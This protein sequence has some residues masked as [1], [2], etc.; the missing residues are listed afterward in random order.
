VQE[1]Q[2]R[3]A[4]PGRTIR[5]LAGPKTLL[6]SEGPWRTLEVLHARQH[7]RPS[8]W[9]TT[10]AQRRACGWHATRRRSGHRGV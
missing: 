8:R 4:R 3:E 2:T 5:L 1:G 9:R 7:N 6:P 10:A